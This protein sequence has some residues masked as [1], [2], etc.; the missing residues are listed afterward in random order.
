MK[1]II[2]LLVALICAAG[3]YAQRDKDLPAFGKIEKADL[4][5]TTCEFDKEADAMLLLDYGDISYQA[6]VRSTFAMRKDMRTRIKILR[7][8]GID[9]ATIRINY[10]TDDNYEKLLDVDAITYNL[11][12]SGNVVTTKVENKSFFKEKIDANYSAIK[13]TFPDVKVGSVVEYRYTIIRQTMDRI[14]PW[15]FQDLIPTKISAYR[16]IIP[17]YFKFTTNQQVSLPV[18]KKV[19][20]Y[21]QSISVSG[22]ILR[23]KGKEQFYK[24]KN[25]P[26]LRDEPYMGAARDYLQRLE[27]Q[28]SQIVYPDFTT[29]NFRNSWQ[30]L[31]KSLMESEIFGKQIRKNLLKSDETNTILANAKTPTEKMLKIYD[32]VQRSMAWNGVEDFY[33]TSVKEAW[34][35]R[36]GSTG[37]INLILLN[38]LRDAGIQAMPILASTRSHGQVYS[39]YPFLR[40]F[41]TLVVY[42][43]IGDDDFILDASDKYNPAH[44][45]PLDVLGTQAYIADLEQGGFVTLWNKRNTNRHFVNFNAAIDAEGQLK[46]TAKLSTYDYGRKARVRL[47]K[48]NK[49]KFTEKYISAGVADIQVKDLELINLTAD[50]LPLDQV[51]AFTAP[52]NKSGDYQFFTL[53]MFTGLHKNLFTAETRQT[54]IEF[55]CNQ[56]FMITGS[57]TIPE[58]FAFEEPPRNAGMILPDTSISFRRF[59]EAKDNMVQFRI[60]LDFKRPVYAVDEYPDFREFYKLLFD[61]LNEQIVFRKK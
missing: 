55:G 39:A 35:K 26:A 40:Q 52:T 22:S 16:I 4:E 33:C 2:A 12:A 42:V 50:S 31:T 18:E 28:L 36:A 54:N 25:V 61:K 3:L 27:Y 45:I 10:I 20:E 56:Q 14:D 8:K 59:L 47:F 34:A 58:G 53:N 19:E 1:K 46:G 6:G 38:L 60:T 11:D 32:H 57:V 41:N 15:V 48:D 23:Y 5:L 51:F 17:E 21:E 13:F 37:D 29:H 49:E 24:M 43:P 7:Q 30:D 44:L 9:H